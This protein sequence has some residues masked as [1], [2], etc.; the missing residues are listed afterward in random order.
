MEYER[1]MGSQKNWYFKATGVGFTTSNGPVASPKFGGT[2][3]FYVGIGIGFRGF[4][5][6]T[7]Y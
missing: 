6:T 5:Y 3:D 7:K 4:K 2:Y 1:T